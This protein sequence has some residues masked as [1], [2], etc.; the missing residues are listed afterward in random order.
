MDG[1]LLRAISDLIGERGSPPAFGP[2]DYGAYF[3][4]ALPHPSLAATTAGVQLEAKSFLRDR[5]HGTP[6]VRADC[7]EGEPSR[8]GPAVTVLSEACYSAASLERFK[9]WWDIEQENAMGLEAPRHTDETAARSAL[10]TALERLRLSAPDLHGE[11]E[12]LITDIVLAT[13]D[14]SQHFVF[15]G[16]S[17]FALWGAMTVNVSAHDHWI[18][19]LQTVVHEAAHNL[20]FALAR[21]APLV[22]NDPNVRYQSPLREDA[23]PMD[24]IFHA[25][26]VSARESLALDALLRWHEASAGLVDAEIELAEGLLSDSVIAFRRCSDILAANARLTPLGEAIL[27]ECE[28]F[29]TSAF[30]VHEA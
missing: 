21:E 16:A 29:M 12:A 20:L 27:A 7:A 28:A 1:A 15:F 17:S 30:A 19:Y 22:L 9:R 13:S 2:L 5:L 3:D 8:R 6:G 10:A 26:F 11:V 24:G 4:L 25:A 18:G 14:G 23:R